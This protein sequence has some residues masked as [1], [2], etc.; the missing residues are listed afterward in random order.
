MRLSLAQ[1]GLRRRP[2]RRKPPLP[3][4]AG[5]DHQRGEILRRH[6]NRR[7]A[8]RPR[9]GSVIADD[10]KGINPEASRSCSG[11]TIME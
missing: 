8:E 2:D 6:E 1:T 4:R 10:G 11:L 5:S 3:H 7:L 9:V